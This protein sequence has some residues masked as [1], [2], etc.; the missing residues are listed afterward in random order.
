MSTTIEELQKVI[1]MLQANTAESIGL[2]G[3][4]IRTIAALR[5]QIAHL[6]EFTNQFVTADGVLMTESRL[7]WWP[8]CA[9]VHLCHINAPT[10]SLF[11]ATGKMEVNLNDCYSTE[12]LAETS[13]A[14]ALAGDET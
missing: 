7:V 5:H 12:E 1:E 8:G 11:L 13:R 4:R 9:K 14:E 10:V 6:E 2:A 3:E